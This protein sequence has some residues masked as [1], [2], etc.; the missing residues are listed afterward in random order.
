MQVCLFLFPFGIGICIQVIIAKFLVQ[1]LNDVFK[2]DLYDN[3]DEEI[4]NNDGNL[5]RI[6]INFCI[7]VTNFALI[8]MRD[9][10]KIQKLSSISIMTVIYNSV[11]IFI[12]MFTGFTHYG[13]PNVE[14]QGIFH[15]DWDVVQWFNFDSR[16]F[17]KHSQAIASFLYVY[18]NHQLVFPT[19]KNM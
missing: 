4:Y 16:S 8:Q 9:I 3:R 13:D 10:S 19:C 17:S 1:I 6:L 11:T 18:I 12:L 7:I 14:Y 5:V 15:L 2:F